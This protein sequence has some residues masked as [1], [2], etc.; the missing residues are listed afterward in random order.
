MG[1]AIATV[2][3]AIDAKIS[4]IP[5]DDTLTKRFIFIIFITFSILFRFLKEIGHGSHRM[6]TLG[7]LFSVRGEEYRK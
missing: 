5:K 2:A 7:K 1:S 4:D 6:S 3:M